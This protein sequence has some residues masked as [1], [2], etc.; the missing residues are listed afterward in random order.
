MGL[1]DVPSGFW[2]HLTY[3]VVEVKRWPAGRMRWSMKV[4]LA[5]FNR[6]KVVG[7]A[8]CFGCFDKKKDREEGVCVNKITTIEVGNILLK[9]MYVHV[10][11]SVYY[12][13]TYKWLGNIGHG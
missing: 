1:L 2:N 12:M 4:P 9:F 8:E 5:K 11:M 6:S 3:A 13:C 7:K 10:C